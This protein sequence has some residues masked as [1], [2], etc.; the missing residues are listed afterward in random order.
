MRI[1]LILMFS[2][3]STWVIGQQTHTIKGSV[4][5]KDTK[6]AIIGATIMITD[7]DP[8]IGTTSDQEGNYILENIPIGRRSLEC[9]YL[10]YSTYKSEG[11]VLN[12]VKEVNLI[13]E[14]TE[15]TVNIDEVVVKALSFANE[16]INDLSIVSTRSFSVEETERIPG[17]VNDPGRMAL[18]YPGVQQG[19][20]D[21]ENDIIIRGNS[22]FG[23]LWRLEGID[24][25]NPNHFARPGTSGG[26]ITVFSA[27]LLDRSDF[28]TGAMPAEYGNA[29]SG[30]FDVHLRAG[31][32]H[33]RE[34]RI[35]IGLLG[36]DFATEGPIKSD[37][38]SYLLNYRYSTLG[39]LNKMGFHLV[40]E[41]VDNDFQDLSFNLNFKGKSL[42]NKY[43][44][45]GMGGLSEEHYRPVA[46]PDAR[47]KN[48]A[49]HWE[50]RIQGSNM[51]LIGM[52]YTR[53]INDKS[54]FNLV[55][56]GMGS[57]IF[58][59]YDTLSLTDERYRYNTQ[60]YLD[61]RL[62]TA[63]SYNLK[64]S[65]RFKLKTGLIAHQVFY[66]FFKETSPRTIT[67]DIN[68]QDNLK[69]ISINGTGNTQTM[70]I[71]AQAS[72]NLSP[73]IDLN[74][75]LH[76]LHLFLNNTNSIEPRLSLKY[77]FKQNQSIN[78]A[79]GTHGKILPFGAYFV[80]H[81]DSLNVTTRPNEN[82]LPIKSDHFITSYHWHAKNGL[83][84][85]A[86]LYFQNLR[87]VPIAS[88][89]REEPYW[90]LNARSDVPEFA[91]QSAGIGSN[92]GIDLA[93]EKFFRTHWYFLLT[94]SMFESQFEVGNGRRYHSQ[95]A[96]RWASTYTIG[97]EFHFKNGSVFQAGLRT[98]YNGG[99]RYTPHDVAASLVEGN[100]VADWD[101]YLSKQV[102]PYFRIDSRISWRIN[103]T[104]WAGNLSLDI[105]N[106]L[107]RQN[108]NSIA[109][110]PETNSLFFQNHPSG[111]IPVLS[112]QIDF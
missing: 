99:Y 92:Y 63:M 60:K 88:D 67:S 25:P 93:I 83:H 108:S 20:D 51:G 102:D 84:F 69:A 37:K 52:T 53:L 28:T 9:K 97:R 1:Y 96:T 65:T 35:K 103:K 47:E 27:Q 3:L 44:V 82:L 55:V 48:I 90:M 8:P 23:M 105:Q 15:E 87:N 22:S 32:E 29:I 34:H 19:G 73:K 18:A 76:Y 40:G 86:E 4:I 107:N 95:F 109:Y 43:S 39:L 58:R 89:D 68:Q 77:Q 79:F 31:N 91:V 56:A 71:Y 5:D 21:S 16:P 7:A 78:F 6:Q 61:F 62:S 104:K 85:N 112:F 54:Y 72:L 46:N 110:D 111:L 98:L 24:I 36:L 41:R 75:G 106:V 14:M 10:G 42:N 11:L 12:S 64:M 66:D 80:S 94:G 2:L 13:I 59:Q 49:N 26:G 17:A 38:S 50:D 45:F 74:G 33:I 81:T 100:Y 30:A 101:R 70:Q 57:E